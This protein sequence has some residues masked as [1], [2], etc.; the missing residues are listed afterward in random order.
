MQIISKENFLTLDVNK[1]TV[2]NYRINLY[3]FIIEFEE[4]LFAFGTGISNEQYGYEEVPYLFE[5]NVKRLVILKDYNRHMTKN[6]RFVFETNYLAYCKKLDKIDESS[7]EYLQLKE[8]AK[9]IIKFSDAKIVFDELREYTE[10]INEKRNEK[11]SKA[12]EP[13]M[14]SINNMIKKAKEQQKNSGI[15]V[16]ENLD[17]DAAK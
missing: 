9:K 8:F 13:Y 4:N 10:E 5:G 1:L 12:I 15:R 17:N 3:D 6:E 16:L 11:L 14:D 7:P 2:K